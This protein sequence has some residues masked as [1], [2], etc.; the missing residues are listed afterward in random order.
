MIYKTGD[1]IVSTS[2]DGSWAFLDVTRGGK[3]LK[4]VVDEDAMSQYLSCQFHPDGLILAT[5]IGISQ[6]KSDNSIKIWDVRE[7]KNVAVFAEHSDMVK[8][9]NFSENGYYLASAC[10]DGIV[11]LWDLRKLK[12][13][14]TLECKIIESRNS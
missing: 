6:P 3:C 2:L 13:V 14:K 12:C 7:Q 9:I 4:K 1:Y 10:D 5:T 11:R 8:S